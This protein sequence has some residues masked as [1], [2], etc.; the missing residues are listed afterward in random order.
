MRSLPDK[1]PYAMFSR[2]AKQIPAPNWEYF[3]QLAEFARISRSAAWR[4]W[5]VGFED[6][7]MDVSVYE[8]AELLWCIEVK[9][10]A[11]GLSTLVRRIVEHGAAIDWEKPD[12]GNDPLRKAKYLAMKRPQWFSAVAIGERHDFS[13]RYFGES[14]E[15]Q[16]DVLPL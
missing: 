10:Q 1:G 12:R 4:G 16:R 3:V 2:S 7:L 9:E 13:V 14:F 15:L 5:S 6:G 11:T 8:G